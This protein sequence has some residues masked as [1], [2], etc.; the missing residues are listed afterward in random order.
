MAYA[1][2]G[3]GLRHEAVIFAGSQGQSSFVFNLIEGVSDHQEV[4]FPRT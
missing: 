3:F 4:I 2:F 1:S